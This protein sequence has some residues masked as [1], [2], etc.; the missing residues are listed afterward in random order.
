[1]DTRDL[2][3]PPA[4]PTDQWRGAGALERRAW[5]THPISQAVETINRVG[6]KPLIA[7]CYTKDCMGQNP[8]RL[9]P[10]EHP[11]QSNH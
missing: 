4:H 11:T 2:W 5:T 7:Y 9:A 6:P 8:I 3:A 1:M 10:S